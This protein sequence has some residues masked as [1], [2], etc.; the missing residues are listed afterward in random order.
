MTKNELIAFYKQR[1]ISTEKIINTLSDLQNTNLTTRLVETE[2]EMQRGEYQ[3][4]IETLFF[5]QGADL[6][7]ITEDQRKLSLEYLHSFL[8]DRYRVELE[9]Y[10]ANKTMIDPE[11]VISGDPIAVKP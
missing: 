5:L 7:E 10:K 8:P 6:N 11:K 2:I 9:Q 3:F 4:F 1:I